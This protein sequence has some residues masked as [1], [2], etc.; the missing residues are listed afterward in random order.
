M[1]NLYFIM[2]LIFA[3]TQALFS[4]TVESQL[5]KLDSL[6]EV[7]TQ[8]IP[9]YSKLEKINKKTGH[10]LVYTKGHEIKLI[11]VFSKDKDLD[12]NVSWYFANGELFYS[13]QKWTDSST[14]S[15][16][17]NEKFYLTNGHLI[18]WIKTDNS[19]VNRD[20]EEFK[21]IDKKLVDY[22]K[23]LITESN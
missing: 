20:S 18:A 7:I 4:Q 17:N 14:G 21:D 9:G 11:T 16:V 12:K 1:K 23:I 3:I 15:L 10:R 22:G 6:K 19:F 8:E 13:E 2:L 5:T